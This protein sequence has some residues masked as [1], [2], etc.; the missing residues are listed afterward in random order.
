MA[1]LGARDPEVRAFLPEPGRQQR[2][3]STPAS[4]GLLSGL[5]VAVKDLFHVDGL[6]TAAGTTLPPD[7][8][9]A[10]ESLVVTALRRAGASILGK[11]AMDEFGYCE[12]ARTRNPRDL[13]RTPG[14]SSSGSA[15]AVASGICELAIGSQTLQSTIVP[16]AYCGVVGFK[17]TFGRVPFDGV[18]LAPSF[19][20]VGMLANSLAGASAAAAALVPDW[21]ESPSRDPVIGVPA[22]PWG[23]RKLHTEGWTSFREHVR[24]L[25]QAGLD[26]R[27]TLL[28]WT[29]DPATTRHWADIVGDLL[30]GEMAAVHATWYSEFSDHYRPRTRAAV[31]RGKD[32]SARRLD[33][34]RAAREALEAALADLASVASIDCWISPSTGSVAP[35]GYESTGDS[36]MTCFWS[37]AGAPAVS[38]P[39]FDGID[40]LPLGVQVTGLR[41]RDESVLAHAHRIAAAL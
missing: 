6:P 19:D 1:R 11:T 23:V 5:P 16:A 29:G 37:L 34:C 13:R 18:P 30:H 10:P 26:L 22:E 12:P 32:V 28:P 33:E 2:L 40:G 35:I 15:A 14:G 8:L 31:E 41:G 4:D 24:T 9:T 38:I 7:V 20:T 27:P 36:W 39:V 3:A 21:S 25:Q 17:P